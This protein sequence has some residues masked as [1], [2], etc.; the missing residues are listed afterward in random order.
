MF[1]AT[2]T[3]RQ[4]DEALIPAGVATTVVNRRAPRRCAGRDTSE[5]TAQRL[6]TLESVAD[7]ETPPVDDEAARM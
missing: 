6:A 7:I 4:L 3:G 5:I 2:A 1:T